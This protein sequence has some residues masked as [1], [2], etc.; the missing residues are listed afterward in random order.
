[1]RLMKKVVH[2]SS[3]FK[4]AE[5]WDIS[6]HISLSSEERQEVARELRHRVFGKKARDVRARLI[7]R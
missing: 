5:L 4:A 3:S 7:M 1:M 2:K 6:Q